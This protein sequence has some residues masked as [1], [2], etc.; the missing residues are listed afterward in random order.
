MPV[1]LNEDLKTTI[2]K[3]LIDGAFRIRDLWKHQDIGTTKENVKG[4]I[5]PHDVLMV[6]LYK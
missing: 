4:T 5:P 1:P 2:R 3:Y 6:R